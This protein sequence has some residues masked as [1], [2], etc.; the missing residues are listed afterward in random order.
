[1]EKFLYFEHKDKIKKTP[2]GK[3]PVN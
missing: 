2:L 1:M 3:K